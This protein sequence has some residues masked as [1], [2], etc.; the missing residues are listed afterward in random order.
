MCCC[1]GQR[2]RSSLEL[3]ADQLTDLSRLGAA[4]RGAAKT[5]LIGAQLASCCRST[6]AED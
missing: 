4:L 5:V 1:L 6:H 2:L 3:G